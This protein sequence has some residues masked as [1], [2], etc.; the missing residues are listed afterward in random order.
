LLFRRAIPAILLSGSLSGCYRYSQYHYGGPTG[1]PPSVVEAQDKFLVIRNDPFDRDSLIWLRDP[2]IRGDS[3]G[4][5]LH[6]CESAE[7]PTG[8]DYSA[9]LN[10]IA[11]I[12][13]REFDLFASFLVFGGGATVV[14]YIL[15]WS[16][17]G[18]SL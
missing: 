7:D 17:P 8:C 13:I 18:C 15:C 11:R 3:I 9:S 10:N 12:G 5:R 16:L 1:V 2:W 14:A 4:G 6:G